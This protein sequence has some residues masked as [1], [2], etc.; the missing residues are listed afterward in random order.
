MH[1]RS[2]F[3]YMSPPRPKMIAVIRMRSDKRK[4]TIPSSDINSK[5]KACDRLSRS[6][7]L[8]PSPLL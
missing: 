3:S 6:T 1:G 2:A 8:L 4:H 7:D 5:C